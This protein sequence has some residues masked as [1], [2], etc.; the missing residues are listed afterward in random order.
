MEINEYQQLAKRTNI[1]PEDEFGLVCLALGVAGEAGEVA[2]CMKKMYRD[3]QDLSE[4]T[5]CELGDVLW[6]VSQLANSL[7]YSLDEVAEH[8]LNKLQSRHNRGVIGGSG[9]DR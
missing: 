3:N 8:N 5:M 2:D 6:Y 9:D 7:G 1:Y 4:P